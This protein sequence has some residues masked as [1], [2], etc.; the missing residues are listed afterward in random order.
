M[1]ARCAAVAG[2]FRDSL[3]AVDDLQQV[4]A[5][6]EVTGIGSIA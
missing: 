6:L 2:P 1:A 5:G 3:V 4:A